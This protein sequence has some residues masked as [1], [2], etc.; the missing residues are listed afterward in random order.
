MLTPESYSPGAV[1]HLRNRSTRSTSGSETD[2]GASPER[3]GFGA[4]R[5]FASTD[6][7]LGLP[8]AYFAALYPAGIPNNSACCFSNVMCVRK[9]R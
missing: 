4:D 6:M 7:N 1:L 8:V 2:A 5:D 9:S 3:L